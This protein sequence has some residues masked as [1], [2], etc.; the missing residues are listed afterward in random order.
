MAT[1]AIDN[2][3]TDQM[4]HIGRWRINSYVQE[5]LLDITESRHESSLT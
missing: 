4:G 3:V 5:Y 2:V 1:D